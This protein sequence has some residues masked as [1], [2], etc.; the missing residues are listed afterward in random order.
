MYQLS[1]DGK[2]ALVTGGSRGIGRAIALALA[3]AGADLAICGRNLPPLEEVAKEIT[4]KGR[5]ALTISTNVRHKDDLVSLVQKTMEKFGKI[6]ILVNNAG[7]NPTMGSILDLEEWSWDSVMNTNL[8]AP[9]LLS[10]MVGK[11]MKEQKSGNIINVSSTSGL[12]A[13]VVLGAYSVSKA[14]IIMLTSV[15]AADLRRYGVRVNCISPGLVRTEFSRALYEGRER[16]GAPQRPAW[17]RLAEA[18]EMAGIVVFLCSDA[19][20]YIN[21]HNIVLDNGTGA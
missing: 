9:F 3:D 1:L 16:E 19:A 17:E 20:S 11:I 12:R 13:S 5:Q 4:A 8:K 2:V 6:D 7:T 10:Q 15:L 14:A 18:E 21:G